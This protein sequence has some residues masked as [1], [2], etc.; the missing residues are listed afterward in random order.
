[1][2]TEGQSL[3]RQFFEELKRRRVIRVATLYVLAL[4]P[5]IQIVDIL[6]PAIGLPATT[7]RYLLLIFIG[8]LPVALILSWLYDLNRGGIVRTTE[9]FAE[10]RTVSGC[11]CNFFGRLA[12]IQVVNL[13][14]VTAEP[15]QVA[16][17][18]GGSR[19]VRRH[20]GGGMRKLEA[21]NPVV[22]RTV[23]VGPDVQ[24][25]ADDFARFSDSRSLPG[26]I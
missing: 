4:W 18:L 9:S 1:M 17:A 22:R 25:I 24:S 15:H 23:F 2:N 3:P 13:S 12:K 7:M 20:G 19:A 8:G 6:S 14:P 21:G 16:V 10:S 11:S 26:N 5:I